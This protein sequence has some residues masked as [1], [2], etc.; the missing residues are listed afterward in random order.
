MTAANEHDDHTGFGCERMDTGMTK[1]RRGR[2]ARPG[3]AV[4]LALMV[5]ASLAAGACDDD[6][7]PQIVITERG[8][9]EG[10]LYFDNDRNGSFDP[11]GG[12]FPVV[13]TQVAARNRGTTENVEGATTGTDGRFVIQGLPVG[14]HDL[15]ID[16]ATVAEGVVYCQNPIPF[17]I[18]ISEVRFQEFVGLNGCV[19]TIAEAESKDPTAGEFVT[20]KGI[21]TSA[22]G[23][24]EDGV[25]TIQDATGGIKTFD[26][27]MD[28]L[29]L[30]RGDRVELSGTLGAFSNELQLSGITVNGVEKA[31]GE[32]AP[33]LT[34]TGA[35]AAA[36]PQARDRLQGL[37]V[38]VEKAEL[39]EAFGSGSLNIQNGRI[40][41]G[42]GTS[43]IRVDDGVWDRNDLANFMQTGKCYD[44]TGIPSNFNGDGQIFPRRADDVTE[45][46]CS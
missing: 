1:R 31:V 40:N 19:I 8:A 46:P 33:E 15:W 12:D 6:P 34:T 2:E 36:G 42:S 14:T 24:I 13:G 41:D 38:T 10:L 39:V 3:R 26:S 5:G 45:V 43:T 7:A 16:T 20:V 30:E 22:P 37:L 27:S 11:A 32:L 35:I 4:V 23:E 9:L 25:G 29:G 21:M 18:Y 44:I 28:G 17:T